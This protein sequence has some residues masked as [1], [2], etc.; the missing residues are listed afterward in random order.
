MNEALRFGIG[1]SGLAGEAFHAPLV[2]AAG[3]RV[4]GIVY[5]ALAA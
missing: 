2:A 4:A 1:G 5:D 3:L